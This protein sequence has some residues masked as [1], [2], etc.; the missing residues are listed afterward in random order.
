MLSQILESYGVD[1]YIARCAC[2]IYGASDTIFYIG[3]V[4]F[5]SLKRKKLPLALGIAL[6]SYF[7]S[8]ILGCFLCRIL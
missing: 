8:I 2:I 3:A 4:Y 1:S 7:L 6:F 5:A